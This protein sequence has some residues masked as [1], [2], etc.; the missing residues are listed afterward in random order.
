MNRRTS[1]K[2]SDIVDFDQSLTPRLELL[3]KISAPLV[4][5]D[6]KG[7]ISAFNLACERLF[8]CLDEDVRGELAWHILAAH[9]DRGAAET[10]FSAIATGA[11]PGKR[12]FL[13]PVKAG[14]WC[15]VEWSGEIIC[16]ADESI[17][18]VIATGADVTERRNGEKALRE[19][20]DRFRTIT[21]NFP[22]SVYR[23]ILNEDGV[24][25]IPYSANRMREVN[26]IGVFDPAKPLVLGDLILPEYREGYAKAWDQSAKY[27]T[28][29]DYEYPM[30]TPSGKIHWIHNLAHPFRDGQ[31]DIVWD[32]I[33]VDITDRK[34][35]ERKLRETYAGL[36]NTVSERTAELAQR[37]EEIKRINED[38]EQRVLERTEQFRIANEGLKRT[39]DDLQQAQEQ[40]IESEKMAALGSL[41]A[42]VAHEINT[43]IGI[44]VTAASHL[45]EASNEITA[46][47]DK[48]TLKKSDFQSYLRTGNES[49]A[50]ILANL[51]RAANLVRSF[52]E[53]AVDQSSE[54]RRQVRLSDYLD[55]IL[56]S[57]RPS[58][59]KGEFKISV[60]C[61]PS[62]EINSYPGAISQIVTNLVMNSIIHAY[63]DGE[64]GTLAINV[65]YEEDEGFIRLIYS[66]D[67]KG[68]PQEH[69]TNIFDPFFTTK[70]GSGG[71]GLGLNVLYNLVT[72]VLRGKVRCESEPGQGATFIIKFPAVVGDAVPS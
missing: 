58:L 52:K 13:R 70:R 34:N 2:A 5:F 24:K 59:K 4:V 50:I 41:V 27:L 16:D 9:E 40:L 1:Q 32:G 44:G 57:L 46:T 31:G 26:E 21:D 64:F 38:L 29:L 35:A 67:G 33:A 51:S 8:G 61:D 11:N 37:N 12:E 69:I 39:L 65:T 54:E 43:P 56:L 66:D 3:K 62:I 63:D 71:S 68:I 6:T 45:Q 18:F 53:V 60:K 42:G 7:K 48:G 36:E 22:I 72:R 28:A 20:E 19:S 30:R 47:F 14:S 25:I 55:S 49:S 10:Y 23:R 17:E 15:M